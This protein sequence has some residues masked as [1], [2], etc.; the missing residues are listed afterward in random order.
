MSAIASS[1]LVEPLAEGDFLLLS[2]PRL[3]AAPV[4]LGQS[5]SGESICIALVVLRFRSTTIMHLRAKNNRPYLLS[6]FVCLMDT[7]QPN[8]RVREPIRH[9]TSY[10]KRRLY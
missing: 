1:R 4:A 9:E 8:R 3:F 7:S 6:S 5:G 10:H 2:L